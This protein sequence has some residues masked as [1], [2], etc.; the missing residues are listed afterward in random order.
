MLIPIRDCC[1]D[2]W[3]EE[4]KALRANQS[5]YDTL[6][7]AQ[8]KWEISCREHPKRELIDPLILEFEEQ[9]AVRRGGLQNVIVDINNEEEDSKVIGSIESPCSQ[10]YH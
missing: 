8:N 9:F 2:P 3:P 5:F 6:T 10:L 1:K 4:L 7:G